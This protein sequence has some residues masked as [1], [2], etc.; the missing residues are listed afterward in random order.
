MCEVKTDTEIVQPGIPLNQR[1]YIYMLCTRSRSIPID[2]WYSYAVG[3][4]SQSTSGTAIT[5]TK[6]RSTSGT[7]LTVPEVD[8]LLG[9][10]LSLYQS[11]IG[12]GLF[13]DLIPRY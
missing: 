4:K 5:C 12:T 9:Q 2:D 8:R 11:T 6:S 1:L 7:A 13:S 10:P 3:T